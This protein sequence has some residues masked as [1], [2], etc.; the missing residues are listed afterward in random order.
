MFVHVHGSSLLTQCCLQQ[1]K[2]CWFLSHEKCSLENQKV[3]ALLLLHSLDH[4]RKNWKS[5]FR[6]VAKNQKTA[7]HII[8]F[9]SFCSYGFSPKE[10][11]WHNFK[12]LR[13]PIIFFTT[14]ERLQHLE[15]Y[16]H[17]IKLF[18]IYFSKIFVD[19][20]CLTKCLLFFQFQKMVKLFCCA[21]IAADQILYI[22]G[23]IFWNFYFFA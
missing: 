10:I 21:E 6:N 1:R 7:Y 19:N 13:Y 12:A 22:T 23:M 5:H 4:Y 15:C 16:L 11:L 3:A 18:C 2:K 14:Y 17:V 8:I 9:S 20:V